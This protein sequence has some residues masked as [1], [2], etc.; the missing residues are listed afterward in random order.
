MYNNLEILKKKVP[1]KKKKNAL[2]ISILST[3]VVCMLLMLNFL[4]HK[5]L[6]QTLT[7]Y[8]KFFEALCHLFQ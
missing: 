3:F 8:F 4:N 7:T 1:K 6:I 5:I 2:I